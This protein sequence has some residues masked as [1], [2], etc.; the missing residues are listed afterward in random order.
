MILK[1]A[2]SRMDFLLLE[3]T[4]SAAVIAPDEPRAFHY[5]PLRLP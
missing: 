5:V 4:S 2:F 1:E 3:R